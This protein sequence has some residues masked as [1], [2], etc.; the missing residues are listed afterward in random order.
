MNDRQLKETT[1]DI[2]SRQIIKVSIDDAVLAE[3][4]VHVLMG[5]DPGIRKV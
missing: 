3:K 1:M 4:R 2:N 5:D